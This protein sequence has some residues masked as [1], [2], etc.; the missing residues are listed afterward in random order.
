MKLI[1]KVDLETHEILVNARAA[2][3][4]ENPEERITQEQYEE[5]V[6]SCFR[7]EVE[8]RMLADIE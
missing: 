5:I 7:A 6:L 8:R 2:L 4:A 3:T 1:R